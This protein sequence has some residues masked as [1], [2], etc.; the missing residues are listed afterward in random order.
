MPTDPLNRAIAAHRAKH[1][2]QA[3]TCMTCTHWAHVDHHADHPAE[4]E[5]HWGMCRRFPPRAMGPDA[6]EPNG[7]GQ[8][9]DSPAGVPTTDGTDWCGEHW[10]RAVKESLTAAEPNHA[11]DFYTDPEMARYST[12]QHYD[13]E[14]EAV[15][16]ITEEDDDSL[17][18]V[19]K[20]RGLKG[21]ADEEYW[22]YLCPFSAKIVG[23][24]IAGW[25]EVRDN[26]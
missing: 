9:T 23:R 1:G 2:D 17:Q 21:H 14:T 12:W 7:Y 18:V 8:I 26:D 11:A 19:W 22:L 13:A 24:V 4:P 25:G 15:W 20:R 3:P 5:A 16:S 6:T 10:P